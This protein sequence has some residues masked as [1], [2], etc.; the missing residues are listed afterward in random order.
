MRETQVR[1]DQIAVF[2]SALYGESKKPLGLK[3]ARDG[4]E[5]WGEI[6]D[7]DQHIGGEDEIR[8]H[9]RFA[10]EKSFEFPAF[11]AIVELGGSGNLDHARR[12][13]DARKMLDTA[14][15][16]R[17]AEPCSAA[18]IDHVFERGAAKAAGR[19]GEKI[20]AA[21]MKLLGQMLVEMIGILIEQAADIGL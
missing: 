19:L 9:G 15:K 20:R 14:A 1:T 11:Q 17:A 13:I 16:C 12:E 8:A 10:V 3:H 5:D 4:V 6:A 18:K 2:S 21:I 7:I